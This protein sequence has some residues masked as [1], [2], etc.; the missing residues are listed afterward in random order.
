MSKKVTLV[1]EDWRDSLDGFLI[2]SVT[3]S[4]DFQVGVFMKESELHALEEDSR[5]PHIDYKIVMRV[6]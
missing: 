1:L 2:K 5:P 4:L 3:N 6:R